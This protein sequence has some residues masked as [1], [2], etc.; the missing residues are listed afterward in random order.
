MN[1]YVF[2]ICGTWR[3]FD[4]Y[5]KNRVK[6]WEKGRQRQSL[7]QRNEWISLILS[8]AALSAIMAAVLNAACKHFL[9]TFKG[10]DHVCVVSVCIQRGIYF[11]KIIWTPSVLHVID[12]SCLV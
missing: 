5:L 2:S 1:L 6:L 3:S 7:L 4:F 12:G 10:Y 11:Y 8:S 9:I